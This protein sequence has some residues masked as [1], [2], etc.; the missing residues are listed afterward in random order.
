MELVW[1]VFG[2]IL[3]RNAMLELYLIKLLMMELQ[4][5]MPKEGEFLVYRIFDLFRRFSHDTSLSSLL[6]VPCSVSP[7]SIDSE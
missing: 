4:L 1:K 6:P 3:M 5:Q 2:H 7:L